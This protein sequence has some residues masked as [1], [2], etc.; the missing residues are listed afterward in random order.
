MKDLQLTDQNKLYESMVVLRRFF[1]I[2]FISN[3]DAQGPLS[4]T[5]KEAASLT[6]C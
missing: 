4:A 1:E 2:F 3:L 6:Q 5:D